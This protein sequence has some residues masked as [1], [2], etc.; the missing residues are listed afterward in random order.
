M[1]ELAE[2]GLTLGADVPVFVRG[3]AAFAEGVGENT[4]AGGSARSGIWWRTWCKY[5]DSGDF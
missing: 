2:M 4:N 1:D 3:H 5:S